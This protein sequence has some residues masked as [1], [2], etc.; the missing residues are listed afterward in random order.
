MKALLKA[1][2]EQITDLVITE[3]LKEMDILPEN[4]SVE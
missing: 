3:A 1:S 2:N 4:I